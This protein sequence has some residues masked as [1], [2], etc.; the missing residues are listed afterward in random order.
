MKT[1]IIFLLIIIMFMVSGCWDRLE[2]EDNAIVIGMGFD[3]NSETGMYKTIVQ[4]ASPLTTQ[5]IEVGG[6]EDKPDYWTVSAWGHTTFDALA[7]IRK[8]VT[9]QIH[10]SHTHIFII[11]EELVTEKGIMPV[12]DALERSRHSRPILLMAIARGDAAEIL[13]ANFPIE[14]L[15]AK[16]LRDIIRDTSAEIGSTTIEMARIFLNK[17]SRPGIEPIAITLELIEEKDNNEGRLNNQ[18]SGENEVDTANDENNNIQQATLPGSP[19]SIRIEGL[20][21]FRKDQFAGFLDGRETRGWNWTQGTIQRTVLNV[22]SPETEGEWVTI[23]TRQT[24]KK[25]EPFIRDGEPLIKLTVKAEGRVFGIMGTATF[26]KKSELTQSL[27]QRLAA[28]IHNDIEIAL[29]RARVL[30]SDIFGFGNCFYRLH[31]EQWKEMEEEWS[32]IF[33]SLPVEINVET[34]I[35]SLG[36]I[37]RSLVPR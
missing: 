26:D 33:T 32:R 10:Y 2:P 24:Y 21:A 31:Y 7:N 3:Y 9:R 34:T 22:E 17:L 14:A 29:D 1:K 18:E 19:P 23:V 20:A 8:K 25:C 4:I 36:M 27:N 5:G 37:N 6:V 12:V 30:E 15:S 28:V 11:S 13:T 16:G 35:I